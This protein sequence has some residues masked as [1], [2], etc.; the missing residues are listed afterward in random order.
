MPV[1]FVV[2]SIAVILRSNESLQPI[3]PAVITSI[4]DK[5]ING[6]KKK[7]YRGKGKLMGDIN[8]W[9][10]EAKSTPKEKQDQL[11]KYLTFLAET[12]ENGC[13]ILT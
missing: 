4:L 2:P 3:K 10:F 8:M 9:E 13:S 11:Q 6:G 1:D 5:I 7:I 12:E